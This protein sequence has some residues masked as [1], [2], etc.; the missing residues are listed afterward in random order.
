MG[1]FTAT[2][3]SENQV[4]HSAHALVGSCS[5]TPSKTI[6]KI[7]N[8]IVYLSHDKFQNTSM[9][10]RFSVRSNKKNIPIKFTCTDILL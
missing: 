9:K 8:N 4:R 6:F 1:Y 10:R 2:R 7:M 5:G 3:K